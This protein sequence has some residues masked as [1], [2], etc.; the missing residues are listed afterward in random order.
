MFSPDSATFFKCSRSF[1]LRSN[2]R[3]FLSFSSFSFCLA[4][5]SRRR[6]SA[7]FLSR[8]FCSLRR[9]SRS[10][11]SLFSLALR[12]RSLSLAAF[13]SSS[14][15][16]RSF[17]SRCWRSLSFFFFFLALFEFAAA[18]SF[19]A[20]DSSC[21][22]SNNRASSAARASASAFSS[23]FFF[24]FF[25]SPT[26]LVGVAVDPSSWRAILDSSVSW[27]VSSSS[28]IDNNSSFCC[29]TLRVINK[30]A[31]WTF[32]RSREQRWTFAL[33]SVT[34]STAASMRFCSTRIARAVSPFFVVTVWSAP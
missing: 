1:S 20:C 33:Y 8:S 32:L 12:C 26:E 21:S 16:S 34:I 4:A 3:C 22:N 9:C 13:S 25:L 18:S 24:F 30:R 29:L 23:V 6:S 10:M 28:L 15:C 14:R 17:C 2:S 31:R 5:A 7:I 27:S 11:R 19:C